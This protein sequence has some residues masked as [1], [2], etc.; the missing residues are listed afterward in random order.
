[1]YVK[2]DDITNLWRQY[3]QI[4]I[5]AQLK[6]LSAHAGLAEL[7]QALKNSDSGSAGLVFS[8]LCAVAPERGNPEIDI[9]AKEIL[10]KA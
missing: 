10:E 4:L 1:M 9:R 2:L 8:P 3:V 7:L 5:K 6:K